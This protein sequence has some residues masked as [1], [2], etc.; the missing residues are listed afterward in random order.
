MRSDRYD[1]QTQRKGNRFP[2]RVVEVKSVE[3]EFHDKPVEGV[4]PDLCA[5]IDFATGTDSPFV[6]VG[7]IG[8]HSA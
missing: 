8:G 7:Y 1:R 2:N 4:S 5:R 6:K 3:V